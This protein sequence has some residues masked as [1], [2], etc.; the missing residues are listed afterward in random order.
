MSFTNT[1]KSVCNNNDLFLYL[2]LDELNLNANVGYCQEVKNTVTTHE[3][4]TEWFEKTK[5]KS[6]VEDNK[7]MDDSWK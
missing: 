6:L 1:S 3:G 5:S 4:L 2:K 7:Q